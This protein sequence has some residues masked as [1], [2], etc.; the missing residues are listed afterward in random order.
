MDSMESNVYG[1]SGAIRVH[2]GICPEKNIVFV[3]GVPLIRLI[4]TA[5]NT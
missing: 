4:E 3:G 1:A 5:V 2:A